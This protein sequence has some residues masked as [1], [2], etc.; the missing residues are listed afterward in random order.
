MANHCSSRIQ[1][2]EDH[3]K[4][5]NVRPG[6]LDGFEKHTQVWQVFRAYHKEVD[7]NYDGLNAQNDSI[8]VEVVAPDNPSVELL[9]V[10]QDN[11][12]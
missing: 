2:Q 1:E 7:H 5:Y 10:T 11:F 9:L 8:S 4:H 6:P 12:K 3:R